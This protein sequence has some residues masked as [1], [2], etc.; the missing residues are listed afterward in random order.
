VDEHF[1]LHEYHCDIL[2]YVCEIVAV[3]GMTKSCV[4]CF[5]YDFKL[6]V[7]C[8]IFIDALHL[9]NKHYDGVSQKK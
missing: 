6:Y 4:V 2:S 5:I 9:I 3:G 8:Y 1:T 7:L